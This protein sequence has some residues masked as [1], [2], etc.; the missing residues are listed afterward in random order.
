MTPNP[1]KCT[2][3]E[4]LAETADRRTTQYKNL[5]KKL[6]ELVSMFGKDSKEVSDFFNQTYTPI[7]N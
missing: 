6:D 3:Y 7:L 5:S 2:V 1:N 4:F